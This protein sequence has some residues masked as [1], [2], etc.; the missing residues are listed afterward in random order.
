LLIPSVEIERESS[1]PGWQ[2]RRNDI[3][4]SQVTLAKTIPEQTS[5]PDGVRGKHYKG[6][7]EGSNVVLLAPDIAESFHDSET[8]NEALRQYLA[9]HR[10]PRSTHAG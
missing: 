9:E 7:V 4:M 5:A 1:S 3:S 8:V 6:Y 2:P 10:S